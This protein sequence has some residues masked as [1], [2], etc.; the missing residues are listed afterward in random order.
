[1]AAAVQGQEDA[2]TDV[3]HPDLLRTEEVRCLEQTL[4]EWCN[5]ILIETGLLIINAVQ[6]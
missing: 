4:G 3:S 6:D 2:A 5:D 1:V